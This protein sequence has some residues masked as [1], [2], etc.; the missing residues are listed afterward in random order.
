MLLEPF[1]DDWRSAARAHCDRSILLSVRLLWDS[2]AD[3]E[4]VQ[5]LLRSGALF[6][7]RGEA[8]DVSGLSRIAIQRIHWSNTL[9]KYR[10]RNQQFFRALST[11]G[12]GLVAQNG[13]SSS[14]SRT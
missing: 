5:I 7:S 4:A 8:I 13:L 14:I 2:F 6:I 3:C 11:S 1:L 12:F 9:L 10:I